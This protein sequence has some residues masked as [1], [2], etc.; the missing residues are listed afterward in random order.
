MV[1][2]YEECDGKLSHVYV[3]GGSA[4]ALKL[5]KQQFAKVVFRPTCGIKSGKI[6][7]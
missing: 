5:W 4:F 1:N 2:D 3:L 6:L 7:S